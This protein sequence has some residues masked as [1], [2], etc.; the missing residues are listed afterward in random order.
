M[1]IAAR[2]LGIQISALTKPAIIEL[3]V[4]LKQ[5]CIPL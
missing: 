4:A 2:D 5:N 1:N 3:V